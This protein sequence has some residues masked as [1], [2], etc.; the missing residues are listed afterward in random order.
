MSVLV[1][2]GT[3]KVGSVAVRHLIE[4][5]LKV[6]VFSHSPDK[7]NKISKQVEI[8]EGDLDNPNT[9]PPALVDIE[10]MIL[11][12]GVHAD[13]QERGLSVINAAKNSNIKRIIYLSLVHDP[14]TERVPFYK[15]KLVIENEFK[16]SHMN[17]SIVRSSS[18]FQSD[19]LLKKDILYKGIF[20]APIGS[21]GVYRI[22]TRD[23]G[24]AM[25]QATINK[26]ND[27]HEYRL[28]GDDPLT[29]KGIAE[30]Y[31]RL[32]DKKIMYGGDDLDKWAS[33][34]KDGFPPW[35]LNSLRIMYGCV[36]KNGMKPYPAEK[37]CHLLPEKLI[38]FEAFASELVNSWQ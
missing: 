1:F 18:F 28:F 13:E 34:K 24:Y 35:S 3:G 37:K 33:F 20:S 16:N 25:A 30:I 38:S 5:N 32:L 21:E 12:L 29:G 17:W 8:I 2:G 7:F 14:G 23:V 27:N 10:D 4:K 11:I 9:I 26:F 31:S 36:Q 22:D 19:A 6:R 15:S